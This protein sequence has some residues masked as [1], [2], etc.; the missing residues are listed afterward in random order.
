MSMSPAQAR[1]SNRIQTRIA[2]P[3]D[4]PTIRHL[5]NHAARQP[6]NTWWW[7]EHLGQDVFTLSFTGRRPVGALFMW[8]DEGPVGWVRL[9]VVADRCSVS[10][11]LDSSLP[12]LYTPLRCRGARRLAWIDNGHWAGP[13]LRVRGFYVQT[14]L[15]TLIKMDRALRSVPARP[16]TVRTARREEIP[17]IR[18]VDHAAFNPPWWLSQ[19]SLER[20]R[21]EAD[22]FLVAEEAGCYVGYAEARL[23]R[24][25]AHI[26]RLA[27]TPRYQGQGVGSLLLNET[28]RCLWEAGAMRVFLNTQEKNHAS[29]RLYRRAGFQE[30]AE[31]TIVWERA[32]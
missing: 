8:P 18:C 5:L 22:C 20:M 31:R 28:L 1:I 25:G 19:A 10:R 17:H 9:A 16:V 4:A 24:G 2:E 15:V 30:L 32:L 12:G 26:G 7:E 13:A 27:V 14:R 21:H 6:L 3:A 11:W 23:V 29:R